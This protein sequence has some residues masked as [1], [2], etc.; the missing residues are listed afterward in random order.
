[1]NRLIADLHFVTMLR[2]VL[3]MVLVLMLFNAW[4]YAPPVD[5]VGSDGGISDPL[6]FVPPAAAEEAYLVTELGNVFIVEDNDPGQTPV[7]N[8]NQGNH[9]DAIGLALGQAIVGSGMYLKSVKTPAEHTLVYHGDGQVTTVPL[10][11]YT[12]LPVDADFAMVYPSGQEI[13]EINVT[14]FDAGYSRYDSH[15]QTLVQTPPHYPDVFRHTGT[16][17]TNVTGM[18]VYRIDQSL[19]DKAVYMTTN[20][21]DPG[22]SVTFATSD[23]DPFGDWVHDR[24]YPVFYMS[25]YNYTA[26]D[27]DRYY[28][29]YYYGYAVNYAN[30]SSSPGVTLHT[31]GHGN[32]NYEALLTSYNQVTEE[33]EDTPGVCNTDYSYVDD[34]PAILDPRNRD[35]TLNFIGPANATAIE[36]FYESNISYRYHNS[37][38]NSC[39]GPAIDRERTVNASLEVW[40]LG[41]RHDALLQVNGT[42]SHTLTV[43]YPYGDPLYMIA[44]PEPVDITMVEFDLAGDRFLVGGL[45]RNTPYVISDGDGND[46]GAGVTS[47]SGSISRTL[48]SISNGL[49]PGDGGVLRLYP[50]A[51]HYDGY[52]NVVS[53]DMRNGAKVDNHHGSNSTFAYVPVIY[54]RLAF[55]AD[56]EVDHVTLKSKILGEMNMDHLAG[57]YLRNQALMVPILPGATALDM[58]INGFEMSV[59]ISDMRVEEGPGFIVKETNS[60]ASSTRSSYIRASSAST[61][62][63]IAIA[64]SNGTMTAEATVWVTGEAELSLV[65]NFE[66]ETTRNRCNATPSGWGS[67]LSY[68]VRWAYGDS[69]PDVGLGYNNFGIRSYYACGLWGGHVTDSDYNDIVNRYGGQTIEEIRTDARLTQLESN[70][71]YNVMVQNNANIARHPIGGNVEVYKNGEYLKTVPFLSS[72]T[73]TVT[74]TYSISGLPTAY[75]PGDVRS[76]EWDIGCRCPTIRHA[77]GSWSTPY[78]MSVR[79]SADVTYPSSQPQALIEV[80]VEAGD[81]VQFV[82]KANLVTGS[83]SAPPMPTVQIDPRVYINGTNTASNGQTEATITI[84][85]GSFDVFCC[86]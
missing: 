36:S 55:I 34:A 4:Q 56:A 60:H 11:P 32:L 8:Q 67:G 80:E 74:S 16:M 21:T 69:N 77:D 12:R 23:V 7:N 52:I 37:Q 42:G 41:F 62:N 83:L 81:M 64:T 71:A 78:T 35:F 57:S 33:V 46:V 44:G 28:R 47:G 3:S 48:G 84:E 24:G 2:L 85:G 43:P 73:P 65:T 15:T 6:R 17:Q 30:L 51:P 9:T 63:G 13:V 26:I 66:I 10:V 22:F 18:T 53:F 27:Y 86:S 70:T 19:Y 76:W 31:T 29:S 25:A 50:G 54:A 20:A 75:L 61:S 79:Q 59:L 5:P 39:P 1:M 82:I 58:T 68:Y 45:P 38:H 14:R 49:V 40:D 72:G